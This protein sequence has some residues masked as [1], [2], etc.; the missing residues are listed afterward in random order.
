MREKV[1]AFT[2]AQ[3]CMSCH[4]TINPLG[5]SLEHFDSIGRWRATDQD[6]PIDA[7]SDFTRDD[8]VSVR[9]TGPRDVAAFAIG[10]TVARQGFVRQL[11]QYA[12]QRDPAELSPSLLDDLVAGFEADEYHVLK[13]YE[14]IAVAAAMYGLPSVTPAANAV[15]HAREQP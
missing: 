11:S 9:L 12:L 7:Q 10:S 3:A 4:E 14:R 2:R 15:E 8:G 1:T 13:L 6:K 5:F